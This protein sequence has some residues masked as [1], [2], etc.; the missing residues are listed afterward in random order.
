MTTMTRDQLHEV[1]QEFARPLL[2]RLDAIE[3]NERERFT[4][5]EVQDAKDR[6][7]RLEQIE[8]ARAEVARRFRTSLAAEMVASSVA[9]GASIPLSVRTAFEM[10]DELIAAGA[11]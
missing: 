2:E 6:F 4:D 7:L 10:A 3:A 9:A 1:L 11:K 5:A 8:E